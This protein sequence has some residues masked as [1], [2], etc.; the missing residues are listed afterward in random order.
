MITVKRADSSSAE[1]AE[2]SISEGVLILAYL[3]SVTTYQAVALAISKPGAKVNLKEV[4]LMLRVFRNVDQIGEWALISAALKVQQ[5]IIRATTDSSP[6]PNWLRTQAGK[7][8]RTKGTIFV[9]YFL[10]HQ[11]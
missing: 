11:I 2:L 9:S 1:L 4:G 8:L 10:R 6:R 7:I 3:P 5:E